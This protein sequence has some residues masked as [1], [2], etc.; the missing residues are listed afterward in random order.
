MSDD[1]PNFRAM[2]AEADKTELPLRKAMATAEM[3][4]I[5]A[6]TNELRR[7]G[8][9]EA[10]YCPKDHSIFW[11]W[12]P[13]CAAPYECYYEGEWPKGSWFAAVHG[14]IWPARPVLWKAKS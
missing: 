5:T 2:W 11:G 9:A 3:E 14:D 4:I 1:M 6:L 13:L 10:I 7:H 8:W 12:D